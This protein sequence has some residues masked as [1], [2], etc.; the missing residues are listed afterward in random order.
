MYLSAR[1][2]SSASTQAAALGQL[3]RTRSCRS[4]SASIRSGCWT[5]TIT[6]SRLSQLAVAYIQKMQREGN[7]T[8]FQTTA[9]RQQ[10]GCVVPYLRATPRLIHI[11]HDRRARL[12]PPASLPCA[13]VPTEVVYG[14]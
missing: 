3:P 2:R 9:A 14:C 8:Q 6:L 10:P 1:E 7:I 12:S 4:V 11:F 5:H 13:R